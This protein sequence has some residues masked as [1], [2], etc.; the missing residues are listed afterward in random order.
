[1]DKLR[2]LTYFVAAAEEGSFSGAG[3]RMQVSTAAVQKLVAALEASLG[4]RLFERTP[5]GLSLTAGGRDYLGACAPL[6]RELDAVDEALARSTQRVSG[7]LT[8]GVHGQIAHHVLGPALH[9]FHERFPEVQVDV[10][11]I[12]RLSDADAADCDVYLLMGWPDV[13]DL[14][15]KRQ[16]PTRTQVLASPG[17]W[18]DHG[19]PKCPDELS[20]HTC[21]LTRNP[22]GTIID[23]WEFQ[24]HGETASVHVDGWLVSS[25]FD[26]L[27]NAAVSG[28][29]VGRFSEETARAAIESGRLVPCLVDWQ[30]VGP[31]MNLLF[32]PSQRRH[33]RVRAFVDFVDRLLV[34]WN[35]RGDAPRVGTE[36]PPSW[37]RRGVVRASAVKRRAPT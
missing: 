2:A 21:L 15:L 26:V 35:G 11:V 18:R 25:G 10:R 29:G 31:P 4:Q 1:M 5:Q 28:Q 12:L 30:M 24:R 22:A 6:L 36:A 37:H 17:Y 33:P 23:L 13:A 16:H 8:V 20:A 3:R 19:V 32:R 34:D 27:L 9:H 14:V 7:L